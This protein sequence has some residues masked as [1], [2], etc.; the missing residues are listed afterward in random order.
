MAKKKIDKN[1]LIVRIIAGTM[2]GILVVAF[3]ATCIANLIN[4]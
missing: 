4:A 3:A 2:V 1:K